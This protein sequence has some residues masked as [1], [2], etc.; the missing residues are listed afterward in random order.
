MNLLD[1]YTKRNIQDYLARYEKKYDEEK[2]L[3]ILIWV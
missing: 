2:L 3:K 1:A